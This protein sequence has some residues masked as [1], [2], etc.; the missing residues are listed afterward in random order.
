VYLKKCFL[1]LKGF[2]WQRK[3]PI[4]EKTTLNK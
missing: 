2:I 1:Y 4:K 3:I